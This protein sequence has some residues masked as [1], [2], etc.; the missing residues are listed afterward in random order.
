MAFFR[1]GDG[2][3]QTGM[4][5][6]LWMPPSVVLQFDGR[7]TQAQIADRIAKTASCPM[8]WHGIRFD[9]IKHAE[10]WCEATCNL[11]FG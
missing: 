3:S 10:T 4:I 9:V 8:S 1:W 5:D 2:I 7:E 6:S 11:V